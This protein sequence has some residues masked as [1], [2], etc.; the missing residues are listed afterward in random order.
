[1]AYTSAEALGGFEFL[2]HLVRDVIDSSLKPLSLF[3][4]H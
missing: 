1:M 2:K 3:K 4:R